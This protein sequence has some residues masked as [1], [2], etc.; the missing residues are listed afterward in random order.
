MKNLKQWFI[1]ISCL[2]IGNGLSAKGIP[3]PGNVLGMLL[4]L[5]LLI[6]GITKL[7]DVEKVSEALIRNLALFLI[8]GNVALINYVD[9]LGEH[10][11]PILGATLIST[12]IVLGTT[13]HVVEF[14]YKTL[15]GDRLDT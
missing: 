13:G 2:L 15:R 1:I 4:L 12:F 6:M 14:V 9:L 10:L 7:E 11:W 8:P 3:V 5:G